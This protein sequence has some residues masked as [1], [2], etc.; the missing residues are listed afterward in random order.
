VNQAYLLNSRFNH[1]V[2]TTILFC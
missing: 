2:R 1:S